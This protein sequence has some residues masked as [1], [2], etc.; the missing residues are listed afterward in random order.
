LVVDEILERRVGSTVFSAQDPDGRDYLVLE[1]TVA[2]DRNWVCAPISPLALRCVRTGRASMRDAFR[3]TATGY[4]LVFHAG[5]EG[6]VA[7]SIVL[8]N[9]IDDD[10]LPSCDEPP[11]RVA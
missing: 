4:L 5:L 9:S 11:V 7:T 1:E 3:H 6:D 8:C 10:L 2:T